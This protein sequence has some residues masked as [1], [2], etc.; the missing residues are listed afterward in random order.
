MSR[1]CWE[2]TKEIRTVGPDVVQINAAIGSCARRAVHSLLRDR[3]PADPNRPPIA[4][5]TRTSQHPS[6]RFRGQCNLHPNR[7]AS[8]CSWTPVTLHQLEPPHLLH[9]DMSVARTRLR[10]QVRVC[11]DVPP[12]N[13]LLL[14][15][16]H[17]LNED[18]SKLLELTVARLLAVRDRLEA[19]GAHPAQLL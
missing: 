10:H 12:V 2:F 9:Y 3:A 11:G 5:F 4:A 18:V 7:T 19:R 8:V 16:T 1:R 14:Q 17:Q 15:R 13:P 6:Q